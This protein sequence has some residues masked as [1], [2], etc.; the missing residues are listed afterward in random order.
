M[1]SQKTFG[2]FYCR[3]PVSYIHVYAFINFPGK[4]TYTPGAPPGKVEGDE[5]SVP[6][7]EGDFPT[8]REA[9]MMSQGIKGKPMS[10]HR[11]Y[12]QYYSK[13]SH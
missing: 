7:D 8:L 13:T 10:N 5:K 12:R 2:R 11:G 4:Q 9:A 6:V 3:I 1:F